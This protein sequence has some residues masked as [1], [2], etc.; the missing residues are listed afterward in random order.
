[1]EEE[2]KEPTC[3]EGPRSGEN[4]EPEE[5]KMEGN[6]KKSVGNERDLPRWDLFGGRWDVEAFLELVGQSD[7]GGK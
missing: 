1:M 6:F 2:K 5:K 4:H 3:R 7:V